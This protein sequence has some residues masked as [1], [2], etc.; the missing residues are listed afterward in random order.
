MYTVI[1]QVNIDND[2]VLDEQAWVAGFMSGN[3]RREE[4]CPYAD[5]AKALAWQS[6]RIEGL[7]KPPGTLPQLRPIPKPV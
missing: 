6:G 2:M 7:A 5:N 1:D 4:P 3:A